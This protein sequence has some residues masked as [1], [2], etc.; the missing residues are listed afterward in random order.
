MTPFD[1]KATTYRPRRA[2]DDEPRGSATL[3]RLPVGV[4]VALFL[5]SVGV[6]LLTRAV[7]SDQDNRLLVQ[8]ANEVSLVLGT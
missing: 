7:E 6:A 2:D 4:L 5:L 1:R 8:R 3:H